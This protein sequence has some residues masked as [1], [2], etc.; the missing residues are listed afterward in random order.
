MANEN[1]NETVSDL[2]GVDYVSLAG[3]GDDGGEGR[4]WDG[5]FVLDPEPN[6]GFVI[7]GARKSKSP[8]KQ[9]PCIE[10]DLKCIDGVNKGRESKT[11]YYLTP[12]AI[13][14]FRHI[15]QVCS[16]PVTM[17]GEITQLVAFVGKQFR[18]QVIN[19]VYTKEAAENMMYPGKEAAQTTK[20]VHKIIKERPWI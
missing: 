6:A 3:F 5:T 9:T 1:E 7:T 8:S 14:R 20:T 16:V 15:R 19:E 18:A 17:P 12:K 13:Q 2:G 10:L 4:T 11:W